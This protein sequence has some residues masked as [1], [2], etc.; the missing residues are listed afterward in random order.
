MRRLRGRLRRRSR[1]AKDERLSKRKV[2]RARKA[3]AGL[4]LRIAKAQARRKGLDHVAVLD[5]TPIALGLKIMLLDAR[6]SGKWNGTLTSGDR[7]TVIARLLHRL[8]KSTQAALYKL[9]KEGKGAPANPPDRGTHQLLGD[10]VVG[11]V[12]EKLPWWRMGMDTS[13]GPELR[14]GLRDLGYEVTQPY[15]NE[16]WH[17]N[18]TANPHDR[19]IERGKV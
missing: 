4:E 9:F 13:L 10:G 19:L 6:K 7:R 16:E 14:A 17:S 15:S 1:E 11:E 12:H 5:G 3:V 18:M 8:G 2:R